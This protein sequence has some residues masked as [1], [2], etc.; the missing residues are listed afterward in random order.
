V[1]VV[2]VCSGKFSGAIYQEIHIG[3]TQDQRLRDICF[4]KSKHKTEKN[5]NLISRSW[6][7]SEFR[8]KIIKG[9]PQKQSILNSWTYWNI[10]NFKTGSTN[11]NTDRSKEFRFG[12]SSYK[13]C[14]V[15]LAIFVVYFAIF[16]LYLAI[17]VVYLAKRIKNYDF[18]NKLICNFEFK[19]LVWIFESFIMIQDLSCIESLKDPTEV[20]ALKTST[21]SLTYESSFNL[22][23]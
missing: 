5:L 19:N 23:C 18:R 9:I 15:Y 4:Q 10:S 16:V 20:H 12:R 7:K 1:Q 11:Y 17:F 3:S 6:K 13:N 22:N 14:V 21:K 8:K 2:V